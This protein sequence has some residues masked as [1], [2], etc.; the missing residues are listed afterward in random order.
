MWHQVRL[1]LY[2]ATLA[3]RAKPLKLRSV[4]GQSVVKNKVLH[5]CCVLGAP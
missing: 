3:S 4:P 5:A 2:N 1:N